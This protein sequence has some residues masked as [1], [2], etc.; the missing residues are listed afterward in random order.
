MARCCGV[1]IG[2]RALLAMAL[3]Q[4]RQLPIEVRQPLRCFLHNLAGHSD[5]ALREF[6]APLAQTAIERFEIARLHARIDAEEL[7]E[8][9]SKRGTFT[10]DLGHCGTDGREGAPQRNRVVRV[11]AQAALS[12]PPTSDESAGAARNTWESRQ[13][14][15][16]QL[17]PARL[18]TEK[19]R[20]C[21]P[22]A[23][24]QLSSKRSAG[25]ATSRC[26]TSSTPRPASGCA[27]AR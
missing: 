17:D 26:R 3:L 8:Q 9:G 21:P 2:V 27:N 18:T 5:L 1:R 7:L 16:K 24:P 10:V 4:E 23:Y 25:M 13:G 14:L 22:P 6:R 20:P 15:P 19:R 12:S 11:A